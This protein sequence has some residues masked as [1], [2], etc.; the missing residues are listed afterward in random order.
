MKEGFKPRLNVQEKK[1]SKARYCV[2]KK[3]TSKHKSKKF[4]KPEEDDAITISII[5]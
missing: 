5:S 2:L 4:P 3:R 1:G